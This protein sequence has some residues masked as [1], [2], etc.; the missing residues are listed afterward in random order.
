MKNFKNLFNWASFKKG[1]MKGYSIP[2]L[3]DSIN[4]IYN[5]LIVRILRVIGGFCAVLILTKSYLYFPETIRWIILI[6]GIIQLLQIVIISIIKLIYGINKLKNNSKDFEVRN[7][8]L[9]HYATKLASMAYCWRVGCT[10]IGGG[11]GFIASAAAIDQ[12]LE[13]G[14]QAKVFLPVIGKGVSFVFGNK[15]KDSLSIYDNIQKNIKELGSAEDRNKYI[16][17]CISKID[18]EDLNN[19]NLSNADRAE[20]KKALK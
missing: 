7:S 15:N 13:V 12:A 2:L 3:P 5:L 20:I 8:P 9:N 1:V 11:A 4:K 17:Q 16:S 18:S 19:I 14:G 10:V 6:I